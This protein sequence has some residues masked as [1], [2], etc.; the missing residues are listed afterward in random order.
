MFSHLFVHEGHSRYLLHH[1]LRRSVVVDKV[2][3]D[4]NGQ[5]APELLA[6]EACARKFKCIFFENLNR[7]KLTIWEG[8]SGVGRDVAILNIFFLT[9]RQETK[10]GGGD[11]GNVDSGQLVFRD[12]SGEEMMAKE[13]KI[14]GF[15]NGKSV[16]VTDRKVSP[17]QPPPLIPSI[18]LTT[19][20][21]RIKGGGTK[22]EKVKE[23]LVGCISIFPRFSVAA[24]LLKIESYSAMNG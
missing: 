13:E 7:R 5:L 21:D 12:F 8:K 16:V 18:F 17:S 3:C 4:C 23:L 11:N 9:R 14:G 19:G 6:R 10:G 20:V 24:V 1:R 22:S 2:G 15:L